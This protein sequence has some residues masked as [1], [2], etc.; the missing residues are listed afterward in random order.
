MDTI[1]QLSQARKL[2][3]RHI[4][5]IVRPVHIKED[6]INPTDETTSPEESPE[7][8]ANDEV[9]VPLPKKQP[10]QSQK[11]QGRP[12]SSNKCAHIKAGGE[13]C[14]KSCTSKYCSSH[15]N[16]KC[17]RKEVYEEEQAKQ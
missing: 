6:T 1:T 3:D 9:V 10:S 17:H 5:T 12:K 8:P 2:L 4:R 11:R 14:G 16:L 7:S 15:K 13:V